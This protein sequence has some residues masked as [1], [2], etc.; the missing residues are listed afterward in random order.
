[1]IG[2]SPHSS[3]D[4]G[5]IDLAMA[6]KYCFGAYSLWVLFD[7]S[8]LLCGECWQ[9]WEQ[10]AVVA[11]WACC[12]AFAVEGLFCLL[13]QFGRM[14]GI[15]RQLRQKRLPGSLLCVV[16]SWEHSVGLASHPLTF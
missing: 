15:V 16:L 4:G 2:M 9:F 13:H 1:M 3:G 12:C 10:F 7:I 6:K 8:V 14:V 11:F 5:F